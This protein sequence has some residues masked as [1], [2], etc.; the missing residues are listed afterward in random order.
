MRGSIGGQVKH[1]STELFRINLI[2]FD[3]EPNDI[4]QVQERYK[5][6]TVNYLI[7]QFI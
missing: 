1:F 4:H 2:L 3:M 7:L 5:E 6:D